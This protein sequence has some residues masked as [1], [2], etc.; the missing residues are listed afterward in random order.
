MTY[1]EIGTRNAR[2]YDRSRVV[3][4]DD[5]AREFGLTSDTVD[6]IL[7]AQTARRPVSTTVTLPADLYRMLDAAAEMRGIST[8]SLIASTL[9][10]IARCDLW[11]MLRGE[12]PY[13]GIVSRTVLMQFLACGVVK[14]RG[15]P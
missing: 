6:K 4:L 12:I 2:I 9:D 1:N 7:R 3:A 11:S 5:L 15:K 10:V 14:G 8:D 13:D